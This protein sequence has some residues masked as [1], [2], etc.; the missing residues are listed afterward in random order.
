MGTQKVAQVGTHKPSNS[1]IGCMA[2]RLPFRSRAHLLLLLFI[3]LRHIEVDRAPKQTCQSS[4]KSSSQVPHFDTQP[5]GWRRSSNTHIPQ[6]QETWV[7]PPQAENRK[8]NALFLHTAT[9][10]S[11]VHGTWSARQLAN[12][13]AFKESL[14]QSFS[15]ETNAFDS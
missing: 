12:S 10:Q 7:S 11:T 13:R 14:H 2:H 6:N 4:T 8:K 9:T 5:T 15:S 1:C 3:W